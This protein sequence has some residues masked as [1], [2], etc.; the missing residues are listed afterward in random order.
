MIRLLQTT[1]KYS[2]KEKWS[3][4]VK[5]RTM[6]PIWFS[7]SIDCRTN[8]FTASM[9]HVS[10]NIEWRI[11]VR[12]LN[13]R[14]NLKSSE[15]RSV[16]AHWR[17]KVKAFASNSG[18]EGLLNNS[19]L[20]SSIDSKTLKKMNESS[21]LAWNKSLFLLKLLFDELMTSHWGKACACVGKI[22]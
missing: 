7:S 3:A 17:I 16:G 21:R 15:M 12:Y 4:M 14:T 22:I 2:S 13:S 18:L 20:Q 1:W 10:R 11:N 9:N 5:I 19:F 6:S 8:G